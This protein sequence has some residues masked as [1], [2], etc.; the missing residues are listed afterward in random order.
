MEKGENLPFGFACVDSSAHS[1][2]EQ[3][4]LVF[5]TPTWLKTFCTCMAF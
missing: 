2:D 3:D 4:R 5:K 1:N